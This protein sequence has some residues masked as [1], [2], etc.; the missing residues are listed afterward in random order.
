MLN[1]KNLA[2]NI[3]KRLGRKTNE[4]RKRGKIPRLAIIYIGSDLSSKSYIGQKE[5]KAQ[6][7]GIQT[8]IYRFR[9]SV[10]DDAI[11]K[12]INKL[13]SSSVNGIII[14][15]PLPKH[16]DKDSII[17]AVAADKDVDGFRPDSKYDS[18]IA[19]AVN[20]ILEYIFRSSRNSNN[21][22]IHK[23]IGWLSTKDI[24]II[25]KGATGGGPVI[26]FFRKKGLNINVIDTKTR[27]KKELLKNADIII[28][29]VGKKSV[30]RA[31][32]IKKGVI[33]IGIG[34]HNENGKLCGDYDENEIKDIASFYTP[35]PGGVGPVN[36]AML[37]KNLAD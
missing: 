33:L 30:I 13:N 19:L 20:Y 26:N 31:N 5:K 8:T 15:Q 27:N 28:S 22:N 1:G 36:V 7:L 2:G 12:L 11:I 10:E 14:Q 32:L 29:A 25:G 3:L 16:L 18:P 4:L 23:F 6:I 24:L 21:K 9:E 37:L 17:M 35:T 34:L